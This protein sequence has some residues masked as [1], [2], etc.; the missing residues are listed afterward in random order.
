MNKCSVCG[1]RTIK[2]ETGF[3]CMNSSCAGA[4]EV[5]ADGVPCECGGVMNYSH[6]SPYGDRIYTCNSCTDTKTY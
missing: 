4:T 3:R 5:I 1:G 6:S 2:T